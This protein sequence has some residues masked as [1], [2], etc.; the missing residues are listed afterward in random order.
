MIIVWQ[1]VM[2][3]VRG[4]LN[5]AKNDDQNVVIKMMFMGE[6]TWTSVEETSIQ[7]A[8]SR[9]HDLNDHWFRWF[10]RIKSL[11]ALIVASL[12]DRSTLLRLAAPV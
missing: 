10:H 7:H 5:I 4:V 11:N 1:A 3:E 2:K 9:N 6:K 8:R 12:W